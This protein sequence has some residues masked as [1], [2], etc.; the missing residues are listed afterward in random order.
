MAGYRITYSTAGSKL[1]MQLSR[2]R[3][4]PPPRQNVLFCSMRPF[5]IVVVPH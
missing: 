5:I 4:N 3:T 1:H 2:E